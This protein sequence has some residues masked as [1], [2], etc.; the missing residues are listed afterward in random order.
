M[1]DIEID[2][3][4]IEKQL[5]SLKRGKA[6]GPD[7]IPVRFYTEYAKELAPLLAAVYRRSLEERSVPKG[8]RSSPFS[9]RDVEQMCR[10]IDLYL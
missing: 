6:A 4:G 3:R 9:R 7:G 10:T 2:D 8:H 1:F 5:K